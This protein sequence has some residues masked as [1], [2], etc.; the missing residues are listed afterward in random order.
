MVVAFGQ[1][2]IAVP[3]TLQVELDW[4][5]VAT[6]LATVLSAAHHQ[7]ASTVRWPLKCT[8]ANYLVFSARY[9]PKNGTY[10]AENTSGDQH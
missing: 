2:V 10:R 4:S 6:Q 7:M 9:V 3:T 8:S 1:M 5:G